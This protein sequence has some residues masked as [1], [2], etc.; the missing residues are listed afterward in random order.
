MMSERPAKKRAVNPFVDAELLD[1][2][3]RLRMNISDA[4]EGRLRMMV[5]GELEKQ[6]LAENRDAIV[7]VNAFIDRHGL[8]AGKLRL[9]HGTGRTIP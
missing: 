5:W 3:G 7:S 8:I 4:L 6:W 1:R 9:A 2:A